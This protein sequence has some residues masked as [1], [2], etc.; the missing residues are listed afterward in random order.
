MLTGK[1]AAMMVVHLVAQMDVFLVEVMDNWWDH[2]RA[3]LRARQKVARRE[4]SWV[5]KMAKH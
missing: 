2:L 3:V 5:D 4:K 1:K